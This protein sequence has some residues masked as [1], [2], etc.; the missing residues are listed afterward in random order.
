MNVPPT[1]D[2]APQF[3]FTKRFW[4]GC[5]VVLLAVSFLVVTLIQ[6]NDARA[7]AANPVTVQATVL[8]VRETGPTF[9]TTGPPDFHITY[10]FAVFD[11]VLRMERKVPKAFART[12]PVGTLWPI[13]VHQND[14][15]IHD[16]YG[17]ETRNTAWD[18]VAVTALMAVFGAVF[19]LSGGNL[20]AL[21]ARKH[22]TPPKFAG[23]IR[24]R[25]TRN[26]LPVRTA[27]RSTACTY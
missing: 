6:A 8:E 5:A 3:Q 7:L 4:V 16:L 12:H 1:T 15:S 26:C 23:I 10:Q 17:G 27:L 19:M 2:W 25:A 14:A 20:A 9:G 11:Q 21:R 18:Y 13:R 24:A 22:N